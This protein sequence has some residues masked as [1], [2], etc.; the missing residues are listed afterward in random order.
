MTA[1]DPYRPATGDVPQQPGQQYGAAPYGAPQ[2]G[3]PAPYAPTGY[4]AGP[5]GRVRST[6]TCVL[7]F[8]VTLG[9][10][11]LYWYFA[12]HDEM[13]RHSGTGLGGPIA[14]LL[15]L[16]V[17]VASPFLSS[18]EIGE[19]Y[20]RRGQTPPVTGVTGLW[21]IPGFLL[22]VLPIVWFVKTN[23]ALND[24]WRSLGAQG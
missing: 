7:L 2:Y 12:T 10:Y 19:L 18:N 13:K 24:Y 17:G 21:V 5:V 9:I 4:G 22:V 1:P 23:G 8:V 6:G 15:A 20:T 14:L 16:F 11:S 3:T